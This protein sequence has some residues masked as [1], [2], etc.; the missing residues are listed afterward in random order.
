MHETRLSELARKAL[1]SA[2]NGPAP[3]MTLY[4]HLSQQ[5]GCS[6]TAELAQ[7]LRCS[8]DSVRRLRADGMPAHKIRGRWKYFLPEVAE[9]LLTQDDQRRR[10]ENQPATSEPSKWKSA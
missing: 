3:E 2:I 1:Q 10:P 4:K 6:T 5:S 9:W 7:I 8:A